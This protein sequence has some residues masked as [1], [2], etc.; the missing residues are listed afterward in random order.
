MTKFSLPGLVAALL[1][2]VA[3]AAVGTAVATPAPAVHAQE[4]LVT[5]SPEPAQG[6]L[7]A[8]RGVLVAVPAD[9]RTVTASVVG[10]AARGAHVVGDIMVMRGV[11]MVLVAVDEPG[12]GPVTVAVR[13]DGDWSRP[14][15]RAQNLALPGLPAIATGMPPADKA[16]TD[17]TAAGYVI[18]TA[19]QF[20]SAVQPLA[21]W[22]RR[23]G[24]HVTV[25][26][27]NETGTS[28]A[29]IKAWLQNAYDTWDLPP[30]YVLLVGDVDTLPTYNY[31][32]NV[33]DLPFAL[34]DGDDFLP[35]LMVGRFS[36][37]NQTEAQTLVAKTVA[38]ERTPDMGQPDWFTR[39][40]LVAGQ[41]AA[42]T[43]KRVVAF[44]GEQ[45]GTL[46]FDPID[47]SISVRDQQ[48]NPIFV[49]YGNYI[50]SPYQQDEDIGIPEGDGPDMVDE[51]IDTGCSF[52]VYRGWA[53]G[54]N[55]WQ[56]PTYTVD[57]IPG[58]ANGSM[59]P[60]VMSFVCLNGNFAADIPCFG[61][62]FTRQG[63]PTGPFK[64]AVAFIGNGEHW[65]HTRFNDAMAISFFERVVDPGIT[66]LGSLMTAGKLRFLDYYPG[67]LQSIGVDPEES[68]IFYLHIYNLLGDPELNFHKAVPTALTVAHALDVH[69]GTSYLAVDVHEADGVTPRPG[70]LVGVVQGTTLLGSAYAGDDGIARVALT[71]PVS[72]GDDVTVTITH[73]DRLAVEDALPVTSGGAFV[74]VTETA[75][76]A[77]GDAVV[78][79]GETVQVTPTLHNGGAAASDAA[80]ATLTLTGPATVVIGTTSVPAIPAGAD[81]TPAQPFTF[82]VATDAQDGDTIL[83][84]VEVQRSGASDWSQ[85]TLPV[86]A[87]S[88]QIV[89]AQ[90][91]GGTAQPGATRDVTLYL[92]NAGSA[93]TAG[94]T[95]AITL[96]DP[97]GAT[98]SGSP[99]PFD[100]LAAASGDTVAT[101]FG[102]TIDADVAVGTGLTFNVDVTTTEGGTSATTVAL[103]VGD[104]D[105]TAPVGPDAYGYYA[106][107][108]ADILY[109]GQSPTY[110]WQELSTD[111]GG[112][113]TRL[114]FQYDNIET[115][116]TVDLPF[117]FTYYGQAFT[118]IRVSDN[119]WISFD[120]ADAHY[121][122]YNWPLPSDEGN[123]ALVAPFWDNLSPEHFA[124]P[125]QNPTGL[126]A[127]GVY[128]RYDIAA[129]TFTVEWSRMR[130][131]KEEIAD[132]Q[133][134]Q[135]VLTPNGSDDGDMLFL[136]KQVANSDYL[137]MF[138]S[139]GIESPDETMGLQLTYDNV[140]TPGMPALGPGLAVR[141]TT[142]APVRVPYTVA[143][144]AAVTAPDGVRISWRTVDERPVIG[145][146]V[147]RLDGAAPASVTPTLLPASARS[148][149]VAGADAA[150]QFALVAHHP[151]GATSRVG[152]VTA[153]GTVARLALG[154][155]SPNPLRGGETA[156]AFAL[157]R[158]GAATLRIYDVR[159]RCVRTLVDG[160]ATAG[161][162]IVTWDGRDGAGRALPDGVY[163]Y[164]LEAAGRTLTRKLLL[165]R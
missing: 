98:V 21:D 127:D 39:A 33:T 30:A 76:D 116:I 1:V 89:A 16:M 69:A 57:D 119:G 43:P 56:P 123:G 66:D 162:A 22:K 11:A 133:T 44:C 130:N 35:D 74:A 65:S 141:I 159:G 111:L 12:S 124:D 20:A 118:S 53:Y 152:T 75:I 24:L 36:V 126:E 71:T 62:V 105:V 109:P 86:R 134:F 117:S 137:R 95:L 50:V 164:R 64:G 106:Y 104:V 161:D 72:A 48:G 139:V 68:A 40:L 151:Y 156:I 13:H 138:A 145:W 101:T 92:T 70:A 108:S 87:P 131:Y 102:L 17:V 90:V 54:P 77:G 73:P 103:V 100:A 3:F 157:P 115:Q 121:N 153:T 155:A 10:G 2:P 78:S 97:V 79:P 142:E 67:E 93:A 154:A 29:A 42:T 49:H 58:L 99:R 122:F 14:S 4:T 41:S 148:I 7:P 63:Q 15:A 165:V 158:A 80:S 163:V 147:L 136:Y 81:G 51:A 88:V 9:A 19:P 55:G 113:G 26:T 37:S 32:G 125:D 129:G 23:K 61:E 46:G 149:V 128:Y 91:A 140:Y 135:V 144:L 132:L 85:F 84:I 107:D 60:V 143:D 45:L 82:T 52:V 31:S 8:A 160:D 112:D 150:A 114:P 5:L 47:P 120:A 83:G 18:V 94:G 27:T 25:V 146:E 38:Y 96:D 59:L 28:A 110:A 34:L 6:Q